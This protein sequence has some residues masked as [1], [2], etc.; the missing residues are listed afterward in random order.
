MRRQRQHRDINSINWV[1]QATIEMPIPDL[2]KSG[3]H[4]SEGHDDFDIFLGTDM[5]HVNGYD[6]MLRRYRGLPANHVE[7]F[8]PHEIADT[9]EITKA[10][11]AIMQKLHVPHELLWW[12]RGWDH[13][14]R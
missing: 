4:F 6:Y 13:P 7:I 8:L 9:Q 3:I 14:R 12:Q 2:E 11:G 10:V 5:L 1:A